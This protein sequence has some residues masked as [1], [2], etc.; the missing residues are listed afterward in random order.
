MVVVVVAAVPVVVVVVVALGL[1]T[2]EVRGRR[3]VMKGGDA[4]VSRPSRAHGPAEKSG[5]GLGAAAREQWQAVR[6]G[7]LWK[8]RHDRD[9]DGRQDVGHLEELHAHGPA[10]D[11]FR[12]TG[13]LDGQR[14][15]LHY[16]PGPQHKVVRDGAAKLLP[17]QVDAEQPRGRRDEIM[18]DAGNGERAWAP[19]SQIGDDKPQGKQVPER[20][21]KASER[22]SERERERKRERDHTHSRSMAAS[23]HQSKQQPHVTTPHLQPCCRGALGACAQIIAITRGVHHDGQECLRRQAARQWRHHAWQRSEGCQPHESKDDHEQHRNNSHH[24]LLKAGGDMVP[25]DGAEA[26][27]VTEWQGHDGCHSTE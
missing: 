17:Q 7:V 20:E 3:G 14:D 26:I 18:K 1:T 25:C 10:G 24:D 6:L 16:P 9:A 22:A 11:R 13:K 2:Q 12:F 23:G 21:K 15:D 19:G 8:E 27:A 5:R 4:L